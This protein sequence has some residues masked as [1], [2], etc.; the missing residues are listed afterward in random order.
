MNAAFIKKNRKILIIAGLCLCI[1]AGTVGGMFAYLTD[2]TDPLP[3]EFVPAKV[4]CAVEGDALNGVV[5]KAKV[6]NTGNIDAYIRAAVVV[7]FV[8]EDGKVLA[9]KPIEGTDYTVTWGA[10]DWQKGA[11]GY[12]YYR[13]AV[14]PDALTSVLIESATAVKVPSGYRLNIQVFATAIQSNPVQAVQEAW[15]VT[16]SGGDMIPG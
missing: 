14:A 5:E 6:R 8:A 15:G 11:D 16:V 1:V 3:N 10:S 7:T 2:R 4:N 12:W 13:K 9:T